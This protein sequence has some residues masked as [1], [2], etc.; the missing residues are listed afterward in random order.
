MSYNPMDTLSFDHPFMIF[1][2]DQK[3]D[4]ILFFGKVVNPA[5]KQ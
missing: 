2:T 4:N 1:I 3:N 5:E